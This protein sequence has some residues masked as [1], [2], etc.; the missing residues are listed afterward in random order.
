VASGGLAKDAAAFGEDESVIVGRKQTNCIF[1][2]VRKIRIFDAVL[3]KQTFSA[4]QV[5]DKD[6][7]SGHV[8]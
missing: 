5:R 6:R 8:T 1:V 4:S 3:K 7:L 2:A